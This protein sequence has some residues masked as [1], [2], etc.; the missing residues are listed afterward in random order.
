MKNSILRRLLGSAILALGLSV[1]HAQTDTEQVQSTTARDSQESSAVRLQSSSAA[2]LEQLKEKFE[3]TFDGIEVDE[4]RPTPF[5]E[6]FEVRI[7]TELLYTNA[8]LDFVLQG[9]LVD[10]ESLTDLTAQRVEELNRV[11]IAELPLEH[12]IKQVKGDGSRSMV[13][14]EDPNCIYCKRLHE[15]LA[16]IDDV[17]VHTLLFP[18]L[19]ADSRT[20]AEHVWCADDPA[21]AWSDWM[22]NEV[23]PAEATCENPIEDLLQLGFN[24]GVQGTPAIFF[25]DGSRVNG[26]LP[27]DKLEAKLQSVQEKMAQEGGLD[28][29]EVQRPDANSSAGSQGQPVEA[30]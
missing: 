29:V 3:Q 8:N 23:E 14:F 22:L 2:A 11:D 15:T 25:A 27:A 4:V 19:A 26:W 30:Q 1:A 6:L 18:I 10:V 28:D 5:T 17:T 9:A 21:Q 7:G 13:V 12:A 20:K 16:D 24:L